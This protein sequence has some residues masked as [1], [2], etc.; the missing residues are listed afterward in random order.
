ESGTSPDRVLVWLLEE[1]G[2]MAAMK[3]GERAEDKDENLRELEDLLSRET[4]VTAFL[5][6]V[7]LVSDTMESQRQ[8]VVD[9]SVIISTLHAAKGLEFPVVFLVGMEEDLLPHKLAK[10]EGS[11][12]IEEERRLAYVGMTRAREHLYLTHARRRF[13]F[14]RME[15]T[16]PSRFLGEIPDEALERKQITLTVRRGVSN[17]FS[18]RF[19]RR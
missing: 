10:D 9:N 1:S 5:E 19:G 18:S 13:V 3:K 11:A 8:G 4:D 6:Q 12:G 7:A 15:S 14:R 17:R 16:T 2:Y